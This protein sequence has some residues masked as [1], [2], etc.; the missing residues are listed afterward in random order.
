MLDR[1]SFAKWQRSAPR[2]P[3]L[4]STVEY[5]EKLDRLRIPSHELSSL[6]AASTS[7]SGHFEERK[8]YRITSSAYRPGMAVPLVRWLKTVGEDSVAIVDGFP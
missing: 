4:E 6:A 3:E 7:P 1:Q 2:D 8:G 5:R